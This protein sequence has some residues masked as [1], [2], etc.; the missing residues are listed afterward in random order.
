MRPRGVPQGKQAL[1]EKHRLTVRLAPRTFALL[2]IFAKERKCTLSDACETATLDYLTPRDD[3]PVET[4]FASLRALQQKVDAL[5]VLIETMVPQQAPEEG[6]LQ[7]ASYADLY[8]PGSA[9]AAL[10]ETAAVDAM[11]PPPRGWRRWLM[12]E[13]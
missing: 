10:P 5:L 9:T 3:A 2:Q 4:L 11:P 6:P 8:A 12:Q 13:V 7:I 1:D